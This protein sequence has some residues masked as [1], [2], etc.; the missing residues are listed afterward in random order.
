MISKQVFLKA[1]KI[2]K[3]R[4]EKKED[5]AEYPYIVIK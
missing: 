3:K 1:A 2:E 5:K 4:K